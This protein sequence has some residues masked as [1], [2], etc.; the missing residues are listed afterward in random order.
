M[1]V[2]TNGI[3]DPI[4]GTLAT[5]NADS[6]SLP[7]HAGQDGKPLE[8]AAQAVKSTWVK[9]LQAVAIGANAATSFE[10][11]VR[12]AVEQVCTQTGWP[13]GHVLRTGPGET[14]ESTS[15]W[16]VDEPERFA[17]FIKATHGIRLKRG[18][19]LPGRVLNEGAVWFN[20][21]SDDPGFTRRK[22]AADAGLRSGLS[23]S[24]VVEDNIV[25]VMEFYSPEEVD[26]EPAFLE[27]M[28]HI[29]TLLGQAGEHRL[30][31]QALIDN[32]ER[33]RQIIETAGDAFIELDADGA[34][35]DWNRQAAETFGWSRDEII[36]QLLCDTIIPERYREA[37]R[38]GLKHY[39]E[40]G[41]GP[42]IGRRVEISAL[43][44]N[45]VEFPIELNLW[46][47]TISDTPKFNAFIHDISERQEA[48]AA[49]EDANRKLKV[50]VEELER[51]NREISELIETREDFR[52]QSLRDPLTNLFN[53]RYMEESLDR[54][55]QRADRSDQSL[56]LIMI[57]LDHFKDVNDT[58][59]HEAGDVVLQSLGKFLQEHIR[60]GDIACRYG[61][62]EFLLILPDAPLEAT[63]KRAH[64]LWEALKDLEIEYEGR[65][66]TPPTMSIGVAV[67]PDHGKTRHAAL[68]AADAALYRAKAAGRDRVVSA[69]ELL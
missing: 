33:T 42:M 43:R 35:T 19:T 29:G 26:P 54:E 23:F 8:E 5:P 56:G 1:M 40:T 45:G 31:E 20:N 69:G 27:V 50:W 62:E 16:H 14:L 34:V 44:R 37:H 58:L 48:R 25:A 15:I 65:R 22:Q 63:R 49:L 47:T 67:V 21:V 60:G 66:L 41:E 18:D 7:G 57:D 64:A 30:I 55:I 53:R 59:G 17:D 11:A 36:G 52:V 13:V 10:E 3:H 61:G 9:L 38:Q 28:E 51:R 12:G 4:G 32:E 39:L 68:R 24:V 2:A 46:A 6:G